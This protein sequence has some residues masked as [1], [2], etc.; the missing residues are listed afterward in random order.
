M[1][2][3]SGTSVYQWSTGGAGIAISSKGDAIFITWPGSPELF[4]YGLPER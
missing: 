1:A 4:K 3:E 2:D